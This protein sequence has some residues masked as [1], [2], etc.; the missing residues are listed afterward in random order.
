MKIRGLLIVEWEAEDG[1]AADKWD[2]LFSRLI[3]KV[4]SMDEPPLTLSDLGLT[5]LRPTADQVQ[6]FVA[7]GSTHII[8]PHQIKRHE[9]DN[10]RKRFSDSEMKLGGKLGLH[11]IPGL[12]ERLEPGGVVPSGECPECGALAYPI[13]RTGE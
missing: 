3:G 13:E 10:C 9:C 4:H 1:P 7:S 2:R 5:L 6:D 8:V 11:N 12:A